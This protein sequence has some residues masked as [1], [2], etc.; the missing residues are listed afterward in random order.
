MK[1][2]LASLLMLFCSISVLP[3]L[4]ANPIPD[5]KDPPSY[6]ASFVALT[7]LVM[8]IASFAVFLIRRK[9]LI[10]QS[11]LYLLALS[12]WV[13]YFAVAIAIG[14]RITQ[15]GYITYAITYI[16][17]ATTLVAIAYSGY[18]IRRRTK[19]VKKL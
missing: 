1:K 4:S 9:G 3:L 11:L 14:R 18:L 16:T 2:V 13:A 8:V 12:C 19:L 6:A 10:K 17:M 7:L 15:F 5:F